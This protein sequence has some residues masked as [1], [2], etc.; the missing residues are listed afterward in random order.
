MKADQEIIAEAIRVEVDE[1][2]GKVFLVF[3]VI[4]EKYRQSIKKTWADD[5]EFVLIN[6]QL[7]LS[8]E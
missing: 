1:N 3:E 6:K 4:N 2:N 8:N 5:I 7:V